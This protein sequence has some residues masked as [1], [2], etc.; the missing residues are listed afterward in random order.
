MRSSMIRFL[1]NGH[2]LLLPIK[3]SP[4]LHRLN[5]HFT[6]FLEATAIRLVVFEW[7]TLCQSR[8]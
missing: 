7:L 6:F 3:L 4:L 2:L 5:P 1:S 8:P